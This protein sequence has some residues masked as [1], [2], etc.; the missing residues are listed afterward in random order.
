M[1]IFTLLTAVMLFGPLLGF[2]Q[3]TDWGALFR[4]GASDSEA[5]RD[6]VR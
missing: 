1:E 2:G 6:K 5:A 4:D 3:S